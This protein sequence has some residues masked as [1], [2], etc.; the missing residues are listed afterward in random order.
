MQED[1][2]ERQEKIVNAVINM[3]LLREA[4]FLSGEINEEDFNGHVVEG[5]C[6]ILQGMNAATPSDIISSTM[7][8]LLISL[9]ES[10]FEF[11]YNFVNLLIGQLE[12]TLEGWSTNVRIR[13]NY[14]KD[15][16]NNLLCGSFSVDYLHRPA[17]HIMEKLSTYQYA[18]Q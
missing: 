7:A 6:I 3:L 12:A 4:R 11:S 13:T 10:C 18:M 5:L 1:D 2:C 14:S 16:N 15:G 8:H 9:D 17:D